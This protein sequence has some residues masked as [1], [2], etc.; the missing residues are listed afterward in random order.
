MVTSALVAC[1]GKSRD[2]LTDHATPSPTMGSMDST[3]SIQ[4]PT[5]PSDSFVT[6]NAAAA[7]HDELC[8]ADDQHPHFPDDADLITKAF[9][10]D[11]KTGGVMPAPASLDDLLKLLGL[12]FKNPNGENG[13]GGNPAFAILGHSSALTARK[14]TTITPTA[15]IFTPPPADGSKPSGYVALAFDPGEQFVE[16]AA[17]DPTVDNVNFY[18]V[19]FD[20]ACTHSAA[21][22][23]NVDLL[24]PRLVTGWSNLRVYEDTSALGDT[25]FDCRVCHQPVDAAVPFLRMQENSA[26]FTHWFSA[27]TEGGKTLLSDFHAAHGQTEDYGG[28]PAALIDKSDPQMLAKLVAQ[29]GFATQPNAFPSATVEAEV[30]LSAPTQPFANTPVGASATW[31]SLYEGAVAGKFIAPPYHD[32]K[33]TDPAKLA[34]MTKAYQSFLAGTATDLPELRDSFLDKGLADMGFAATPGLDG[35]S[36]L[37]QMCAEC[38]NANLDPTVSRDSFLVDKLDSMSRAEK[39]LAIERIKTQTDTRLTMPPPLFRTLTADER[40]RMIDV[41][42]M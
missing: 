35:R 27:G 19:F 15:F 38:H 17:H 39:D 23:T 8:T 36:L 11:K 12:D 42:S 34:T 10:Q 29:S 3:A 13:A 30:K 2:E 4:A 7:A 32:V 9:C 33:V 1:S 40:Q 31:L 25:V 26:P 16:V 18:V 37:N 22:C 28:I 14:V 6:L 41:L 24:T 5:L 21:G 20:Q